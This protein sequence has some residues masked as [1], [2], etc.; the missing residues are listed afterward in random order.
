MEILYFIIMLLIWIIYVTVIIVSA[1]NNINGKRKAIIIS[2]L[3]AII[4]IL[5]LISVKI[6]PDN[7]KPIDVYRGKT[8]LKITKTYRDSIII[9]IDSVVV[10]KKLK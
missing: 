7:V 8:E 3:T 10:Y 5:T 2:I 9:G 4:I 1:I 6:N